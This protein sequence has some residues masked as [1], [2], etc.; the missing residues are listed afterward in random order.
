MAKRKKKK[1]KTNQKGV[2]YRVLYASI[3]KAVTAT[4]FNYFRFRDECMKLD[5]SVI[6]WKF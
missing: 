1:P 2:A 6:I 3:Y 5:F 4:K